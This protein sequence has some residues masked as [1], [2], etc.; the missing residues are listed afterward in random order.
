[1]GDSADDAERG[2]EVPE[3]SAGAPAAEA[4]APVNQAKRT[5]VA[6]FGE[7]GDDSDDEQGRG[8][9]DGDGDDGEDGP[10]IATKRSQRAKKTSELK[11]R[12]QRLAQGK[13]AEGASCE[14][15]RQASPNAAASALQRRRPSARSR[16]P[17]PT[18][19]PLPRKA[20]PKSCASLVRPQPRQPPQMLW[21]QLLR[22]PWTTARTTEKACAPP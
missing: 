16:T 21:A 12:L 5:I 11:Q 18:T 22:P 1:M 4:A 17:H 2:A 8:E 15:A 9:G 6:L 10:A 20:S 7:D 14:R 13:K 19:I 3:P